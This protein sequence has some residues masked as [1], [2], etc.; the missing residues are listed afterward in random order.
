MPYIPKLERLKIDQAAEE[1]ASRIST[2]G[3]MAYALFRLWDLFCGVAPVQ[4]RVLPDRFS[5]IA[6]LS[7]TVQEAWAEWRTR[8]IALYERLKLEANGDV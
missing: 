2:P 3:Q 6:V 5:D 7:G 1:L 8:R 4:G